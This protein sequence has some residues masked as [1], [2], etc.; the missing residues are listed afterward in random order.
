MKIKGH[1]Q[2]KVLSVSEIDRLFTWGFKGDSPTETLRERDR[3]LFGICLHTGCRISE[4]LALTFDDLAPRLSDS[5]KANYQ[6]QES[7]P[8]HSD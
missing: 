7:Q 4:A 3:A 6:G 8:Y 1:G 5:A 2:A